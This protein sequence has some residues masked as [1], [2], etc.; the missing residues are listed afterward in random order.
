MSAK[1]QSNKR[2]RDIITVLEGMQR[3]AYVAS[4][5][6]SKSYYTNS[7]SLSRLLSF[8]ILTCDTMIILFGQNGEALGDTWKKYSKSKPFD[9]VME[10]PKHLLLRSKNI[11]NSDPLELTRRAIFI[12][13]N[14]ITFSSAASHKVYRRLTSQYHQEMYKKYSKD[15]SSSSSKLI[16]ICV[17]KDKRYVSNKRYSQ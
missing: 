10:D 5:Q 12:G 3:V 1:V 17:W 7:K 4:K 13:E 11:S 14:L 9:N 6:V 16:F 2:L 8:A 15:K